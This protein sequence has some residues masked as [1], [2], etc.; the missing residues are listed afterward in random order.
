MGKAGR[1]GGVPWLPT[2]RR[3][4]VYVL[5]HPGGVTAIPA[6]GGFPVE[7]LDRAK[8]ATT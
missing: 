4:G 1:I 7:D 5:L 3:R 8:P 2:A 6:G